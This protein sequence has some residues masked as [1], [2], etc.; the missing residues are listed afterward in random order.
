MKTIIITLAL[1]ILGVFIGNDLLLGAGENSLK[2]NSEVI[3]QQ[4]PDEIGT[5]GLGE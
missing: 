1:I 2:T 5:I 3:M 4:A